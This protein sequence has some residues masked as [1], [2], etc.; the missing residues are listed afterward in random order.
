VTSARQVSLTGR[1]ARLGFVAPDRAL[2]LLGDRALAGL[3]A[4]VLDPVDGTVPAGLGDC[5]DPDGALLALVR[6]RERLA[7]TAGRAEFD[8]TLVAPNPLRHKLFAVLGASVALADHLARHPDQWRVLAEEDPPADLRADLLTAVGADPAAELPVATAEDPLDTLRVAYNRRL[9]S[10]A[11]RDLAAPD[12]LSVVPLVARELAD[13][14]SAALEA[15]LAIARSELPDDAAPCRIAVIGMGKCGGLE[16]N[17]VSDVDVVYV[18]EPVGPDGDEDAALATG[19]KLAAGLARACSATTAEGTLWPVDANLRPEGR[20]GPLVRTLA[21]H[22]AYYERWAQ[23]WEF[24]ALLKART[25]AGDRELGDAYLDMVAPLV[26]SASERDNFVDDVQAMRRRVEE[27][28]RTNGRA[29]DADRQLKLGPGGLRDVEFAVQLL[30]LVHG[31]VDPRLRTP[32]TWQAM[33]ALSTYGYVGRGDAS[34]MD[35]AYRMLRALEHRIQLHRLRRSQVVPS[36]E[37]DLRRLGRSFG[38]RTTPGEQL[39][40]LWRRN[41]VEARRLHEKLFYR[42]LLGAAAALTA[43]EARLTPEAASA[44]LAALGYHNPAGALRHLSALTDGVSRRASIQRQLLPVMLDW[45]ADGA[46]PDAGLLAFRRL[47]E[48]LG[49]T[50]WYLKILRDSGSAAERLAHV[51]SS[52]AML[53][54]LLE[55]GPEAVAMLETDQAL[56]PIGLPAM[57]DLVRRGSVRYAD[58]PVGGGM[59]ARAIRRR[60]IVRAGVADVVGLADLETVGHM[61]SDAATAALEGALAA[62]ASAVAKRYAGTLPTRLAVIAMGRLGGREINYGSDADVLFVHDPLPGADPG[63]AAQAALAV[64]TELRRLLGLTGPEPVLPV[65]ADLRPEGRQGPLVRS[66]AAYAEYYQRW[67]VPW[68]AQALTRARPVA[69]DAELGAAFVAL[70]DPVRWPAG[71]LDEE[72]V[73]EIRRIKARVEAE[74][75]PRGADPHR[76]VKLGRG[77]LADVEWTVQLFQLRH[78]GELPQLRVT[79]TLPALAAALEAGLLDEADAEVMA[80]AWRLASRVRNATMLWRGRPNDVPPSNRR[81]LDGVARLAGYPP[82]SADRLEEDYQRATRRCRTVVERLFYG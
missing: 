12:P 39:T 30:Q 79:G 72:G 4:E 43:D 65:D 19:T 53:A 50:H 81:D 27:E 75:L 14:A 36:D 17:Y 35:R 45:F 48:T 44:R 13:M 11:G 58:D 42:P 2:T 21:S 59:A 26:W 1:L 16:L 55:K 49:S 38:F 46:D 3:P 32:N 29:K 37:S 23:T 67:S 52:S 41:G 78:A 25:V 5:P 73:R 68:E 63:D 77:G 31:R 28:S 20:Q 24:Q 34:E 69:G 56:A 54:D 74:R 71:G 6:I 8:A 64:V 76:H 51:L 70:A 62:A 22:R 15:A 80:G 60:E 9:L 40:A 10:L 82:A 61:L 57:L 66:L 47:S 18:V 33:E 7:G